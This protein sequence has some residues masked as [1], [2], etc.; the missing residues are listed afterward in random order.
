MEL[1]G[2]GAVAGKQG[3]GT[4]AITPL[5]LQMAS[6]PL[7]PTL[8]R[9]LLEATHEGCTRDV[10][11]LVSLMG[12][13]DGVF[14]SSAASQD[15]ARAAHA[16]F[17]HRE[18]DHLMLLSVLRAFDD[19]PQQ[20]R[21]EWCRANYIG[22]RALLNVA[23]SRRQLRERLQRL[24]IDPDVG[25]ASAGDDGSGDASIL[26]ACLTGLFANVATLTP[27]GNSYAHRM[28]RQPVAIH[29]SSC[30]HGKRHAAIMYDELVLT[31]RTYART[32][33]VVD[34]RWLQEK[35]PQIYSAQVQAASEK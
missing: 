24:G 22:M 2:L 15:E 25:V 34:V 29:P 8:A 1:M 21:R 32:C 27:D 6:L 7:E 30:L 9:V 5:G 4:M 33:S 17:T 35:V 13:R 12:N 20:E 3:L 11:D 31:S 19:V 23:E 26:R 16:R 28:T 14:V 10:I 18:G